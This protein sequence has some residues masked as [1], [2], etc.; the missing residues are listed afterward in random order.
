MVP[1]RNQAQDARAEGKRIIVEGLQQ[2][3]GI[4]ILKS[5]VPRQPAIADVG[6]SSLAAL[7]GNPATRAIFEGLGQEIQ[8]RVRHEHQ[9]AA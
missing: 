8:S 3:P 6:E 2:F 5:K 9:A 7:T 4:G 1:P